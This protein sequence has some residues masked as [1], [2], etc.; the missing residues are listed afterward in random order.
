MHDAPETLVYLKTDVEILYET[1]HSLQQRLE[2][3]NDDTDLSEAQKSNLR[4]MKP[5]LDAC[6]ITCDAF[7]AK[8]RQLSRHS[9]DAHVS[10]RDRLK[11]QFQEKEIMAFQARLSSYK[12]TFAIAL[13]FSSL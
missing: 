3:R 6:R 1:I 12:S 9:T 8:I 5:A 4:E 2:V 7:Q 13:E 10:L 11:M